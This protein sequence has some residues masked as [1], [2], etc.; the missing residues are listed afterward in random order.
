MKFKVGDKVVKA[1]G[2]KWS[3]GDKYKTITECSKFDGRSRYELSNNNLYWFDYELKFYVEEP[4][5]EFRLEDIAGNA[6]PGIY[7]AVNEKLIV[8]KITKLDNGFLEF[9]LADNDYGFAMKPLE[10][11]FI[12][13]EFKKTKAI[14]HVEHQKNGKLYEFISSQLLPDGEFVVCDTKYGKSYGKIVNTEFKDLT[15]SEIKEYKECWRA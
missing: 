3:N 9:I 2:S 15:E 11:K 6:K 8:Q 5:T 14:Y 10:D 13:Q 12:F 7:K 1:G 4:Q